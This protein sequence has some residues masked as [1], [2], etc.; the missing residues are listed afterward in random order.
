MGPDARRRP[1][2]YAGE[3]TRLTSRKELSGFYVYG[4]AAE[5][6]FPTSALFPTQLY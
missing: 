4:W 5:V 2:H 3:D 6:R 1:R